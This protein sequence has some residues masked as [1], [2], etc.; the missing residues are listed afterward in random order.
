MVELLTYL[1]GLAI[2]L[3]VFICAWWFLRDGLPK[4]LA[5]FNLLQGPA[6][7]SKWVFLAGGLLVLA[8]SVA[9][10]IGF[11]NLLSKLLESL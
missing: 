2:V 5:R 10:T 6:T 4:V 7:G 3:T 9:V 1:L 8:A 11:I